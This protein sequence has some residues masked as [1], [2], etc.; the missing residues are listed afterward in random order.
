M[1]NVDKDEKKDIL[2]EYES[3]FIS[4]YKDNKDDTEIIKKLGDPVKISKEINAMTAINRV[5][6]E[7]NI[8]IATFSIM[9]L[10]IFNFIS[11][12]FSFFVLLLLLP[13]ILAYVIAVPIMIVSPII[14][15]VIG[16]INGFDTISMNDIF[17]VI[18]GVILG[19]ILGFMGYFV[20]KYFLNFVV[21]Y[22]KWDMA[23]LRKEKL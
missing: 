23:I 3:H 14:L 7:K 15:L 5:E 20:A 11:I 17:E 18:K 2:N 1:K 10:S 21:L 9:S 16:V 4:G 13:L 6:K 22:L 19:I 12:I 8:F